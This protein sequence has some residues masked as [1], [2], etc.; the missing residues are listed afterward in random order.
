MSKHLE[1]FR[2]RRATPHTATLVQSTSVAS[3]RLFT[4]EILAI[5]SN[6]A[7]RTRKVLSHC[8]VKDRV[9]FVD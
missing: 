3:R 2:D 7:L 5:L 6:E 1:R 8:D 4:I 9:S